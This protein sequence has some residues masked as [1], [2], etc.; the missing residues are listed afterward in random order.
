MRFAAR[1]GVLPGLS[2]TFGTTVTYLGLVVLLPVAALLWRAGGLSGAEFV[3]AAFGPRALATYRLTVG[4]ALA[5]VLFNGIAGLILAWVLARYDFPG[6]RLLDACVD[7]PFA[8]PTA[9]A[10]V[11]LTATVSGDGLF[12]PLL[13]ALGWQVDHA[14]PGIALAM[15]FTSLPF[16]VRSVQPVIEDLDHDTEEAGR[17]L[18]ADE[19]QVLGRVIL[20]VIAP[21][22][23]TG[24]TLAF[25]RCLGE[26]GA[27]IFIAGNRPFET[28]ITSL[29]IY[30]RLE[31]YDYPAATAIA[32]TVLGASFLVMLAANAIQAWQQRWL[33]KG[34]V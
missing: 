29:L 17:I 34:Q 3:S 14:P 30:I 5:A 16:V 10:G 25:A 24:M 8:L 15:A 26:F 32:A 23:L 21:S 1:A 27:I 7:I 33:G 18:G 4:A 2:L 22:L 9:V 31:E 13:T 6:R 28:E 19:S 12:A 11:A 20:P